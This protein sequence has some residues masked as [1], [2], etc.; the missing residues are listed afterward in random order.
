M[1]G[2]NGMKE[3]I[4]IMEREQEIQAGLVSVKRIIGEMILRL[5]KEGATFEQAVDL[6]YARFEND[7][8]EILQLLWLKS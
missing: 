8:P 5:L 1:N 7:C 3:E 4:G 6:A 2:M